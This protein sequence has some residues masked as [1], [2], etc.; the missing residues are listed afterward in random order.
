MILADASQWPFLGSLILLG[1]FVGI[2]TGIFG[3]GGAFLIVPVLI[4]FWR[5]DPS[6]AIGTAMALSLVTGAYGFAGHL[7]LKNVEPVSVTIVGLTTALATVGGKWLQD[8]L[9]AVSGDYFEFSMKLLLVAVV[10]PMACL[11]WLAAKRDVKPVLSNPWF[12][13]PP[14]ISLKRAGLQEVSLTAMLLCGIGVGLMKGMTA[15]GAGIIIVPVLIWVVGLSPLMAVGTSLGAMIISSI[16][17]VVV[18]AAK[19]EVAWS[20]VAALLI[21]GLLGTTLGLKLVQRL[22][23]AKL[24]R[25]FPVILILVAASM[26]AELLFRR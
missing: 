11:M 17:G 21:G 25:Y 16:A 23:N 19:G 26:I 12:K 4:S 18:Y 20:F 14:F 10:V 5:V 13:I 8:Q 1:F 22:N 24:K 9:R 2:L 6:L 15:I 7:R 3:V